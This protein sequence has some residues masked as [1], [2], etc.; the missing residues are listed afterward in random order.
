MAKQLIDTVSGLVAPS[1]KPYIPTIT[2]WNRLEGRPRTANFARA[3]KA[4]IRDPLWMLSKQQQMGEFKGEDAASAILAKVYMKTTSLTKYQPG[5]DITIPFENDI[6]LEVKV[7]HQEIPFKIGAQEI[8]LDLRLLMGRHWLKLLKQEGFTLKNQYLAASAYRFVAPD[9]NL[10]DDVQICAHVEVWQQFAAVASRSIDGYKLYRG[11][12]AGNDQVPA[13]IGSE[14]Q[15]DALRDKFIRWFEN[16]YYQPIDKDNPSWKPSYLEHQFACSAPKSGQE[17]VL[18]ADEYCHGHLDWYNMDIHDKKTVLP[19]ANNGRTFSSVENTYTLNF[20]PSPVEFGGMPHSRWW[21]LEDWKTNLGKIN[22]S[23]TDLNQL[24]LLDFG[25]NYANDWLMMP[26][27][28]PIG[29]I[30][31]VGGVMVTNTFGENIWIEAAGKGNDEDWQRWSMFNLSVRG[32]MNVPADLSLLLLPAAPKVLEGQPLEEIFMLR[33]EIANLVWGVESKVPLATGKSKSGKEAGIE[34]KTKYQQLVTPVTT[35]PAIEN[36]AKI[37]YRIVNTVPEQW[38]PF[39]PV[40]KD[41]DKRQIQLQRAAMPRILEGNSS[42]P[43]KVEPRTSILREGLDE[44]VKAPYFIHEEEVPRSGIKIHKSFQRT[45]WLNGK[46]FT[47]VGFRK[48]VGRGEGHSG[49]A[50]D[51]IIP[52]E[53]KE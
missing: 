33:D 30:A 42:T 4:E 10:E 9:P 16:L 3:L 8:S 21:T 22:P 7:E 35:V 1:F 23:T 27:T 51:Q 2:L 39:I 19:E 13:P 32:N 34:L 24:M 48:Q 38:I 50:F 52:K 12:K 15:L 53:K 18:V 36:E 5:D 28:L 11:L 40:H 20:L 25:I 14:I 37:Q 46:V 6:P 41:N 29:S 31:N 17:K 49:L 45:R 44:V 47:W 43:K 26:F